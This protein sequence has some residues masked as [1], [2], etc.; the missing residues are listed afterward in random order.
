MAIDKSIKIKTTN[1][2]ILKQETYN[3]EPHEKLI[4]IYLS[5]PRKPPQQQ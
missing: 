4:D 5:F 1:R 2:I 3:M